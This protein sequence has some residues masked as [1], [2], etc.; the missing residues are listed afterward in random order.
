MGTLTRFDLPAMR[1]RFN[2]AALVETGTASGD[3]IEVA[4]HAGFEVLHTIEIVPELAAAARARFRADPRVQVW[5]G[6]SAA[7]LPMIL[8]ELPARP[9]LFWLDAHFPGAHT[10]APYDAEPDV[11]RRLPLEREIAL[12]SA[13][14]PGV[15]DVLLVDDA[16][17][18]QPG[19]YAAG[20][21]PADWPPLAGLARNLDFVR[22]RYARTHGIVIDH[23]DQGYLMIFPKAA[24]CTA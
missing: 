9:V 4:R 18:Y 3:S 8:K 10:G 12:I 24:P 17:I 21:L 2:L 14:R 1:R 15:P 5:E 11:A 19:D 7:C 23:A 13:A 20:N 16:R 22:A 6:D